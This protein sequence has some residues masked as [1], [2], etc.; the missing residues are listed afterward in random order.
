MCISPLHGT[1]AVSYYYTTKKC[2]WHLYNLMLMKFKD[3][4]FLEKEILLPEI[5]EET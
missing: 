1:A 4:L 3:I 2:T 5:V